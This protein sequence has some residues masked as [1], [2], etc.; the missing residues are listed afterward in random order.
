MGKMVRV[1]DLVRVNVVGV[2][3]LCGLHAVVI[4]IYVVH[5]L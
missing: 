1:N 2:V 4:L 5:D 3:V